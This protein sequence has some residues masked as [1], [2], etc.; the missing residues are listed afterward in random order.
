VSSDDI[1]T[2]CGFSDFSA[3]A[4]AVTMRQILLRILDR[5][6]FIESGGVGH[7]VS[8]LTVVEFPGLWIMFL[9]GR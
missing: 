5:L 4:T 1:S 6:C 9:T 8:G 7:I 3:L 2:T